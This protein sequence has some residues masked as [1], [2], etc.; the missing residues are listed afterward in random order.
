M[1]LFGVLLNLHGLL[2]II[3]PQILWFLTEGWTFKDAEPSDA[4]TI[5]GR[6]FGVFTLVVGIYLVSR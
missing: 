2:S 3:S 5:F 6:I 4:V 1:F